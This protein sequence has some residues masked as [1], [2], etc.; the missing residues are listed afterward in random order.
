MS[1]FYD[2]LETRL[3]RGPRSRLDG[4]PARAN[5]PCTSAYRLRLPIS[6]PGWMPPSITSRAALAQLP[7][8]RKYELLERQQAQRATKP[9]GGF[10]HARLWP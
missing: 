8:T 9:F 2:A 10:A 4:S 5:C 7:V 6:W 1:A 3:P